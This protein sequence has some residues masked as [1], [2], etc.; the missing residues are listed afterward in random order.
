[1]KRRKGDATPEEDNPNGLQKDKEEPGTPPSSSAAS[2]SASCAAEQEN[3]TE[4]K[5][6]E[7]H[8]K[9]RK[10]EQ[11]RFPQPTIKKHSLL[12]NTSDK[13]KQGFL[14][15]AQ[16][17]RV[18]ECMRDLLRFLNLYAEEPP[19]T[20][21]EENQKE[22]KEDH[23]GCQPQENRELGESFTIYNAGGIKGMF[24]VCMKDRRVTP[25]AFLD[26]IVQHPSF[27]NNATSLCKWCYRLIPL[28][29]ICLATQN[30]I[31]ATTKELITTSSSPFILAN[32]NNVTPL[33][34]A[35]VFNKRNNPNVDKMECINAIAAQVPHP[36]YVDLSFPNIVIL[37]EIIKS[38]CGVS[39]CE[40]Y[41]SYNKYNMQ[42]ILLK[43][44]K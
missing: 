38:A 37:I 4:E 10:T 16:K 3:G 42:K 17:N 21:I 23:D 39:L 25:E 15:S 1:M 13:T 20:S 8:T 11:P 12:F 7:S 26:Q 44:N 41:D 5:E 30:E 22:T 32:K 9:R 2:C 33:K 35:I 14:V 31:I 19:H 18:T 36:H 27:V 28:Q 43:Y 34:F 40:N 24:V 29:R 6:K